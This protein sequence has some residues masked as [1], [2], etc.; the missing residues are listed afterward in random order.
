VAPT[1]VVRWLEDEKAG[2]S[3]EMRQEGIGM[4]RGT[5]SAYLLI[6]IF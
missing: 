3:R 2:R 5:S 1:K 4:V 6:Q